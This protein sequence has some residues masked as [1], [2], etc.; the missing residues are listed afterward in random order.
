MTQLH[1]DILLA[2]TGDPLARARIEIIERLDPMG[3]TQ[4]CDEIAQ[5]LAERW[6][7]NP[8]ETESSHR[9]RVGEEVK[10]WFALHPYPPILVGIP[11]YT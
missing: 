2:K 5:A 1:Q 10:S 6:K 7:R 11:Y 9:A 8:G 4:A 3:Y